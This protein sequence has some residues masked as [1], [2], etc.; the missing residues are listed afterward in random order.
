M[1]VENQ[2]NRGLQIRADF[3][4]LLVVAIWGSSY[5]FM[6]MGLESI[7]EF[8]LVALRF[9]FAFIL[10]GLFFYKRMM[11]V[12]KTT[13]KYGFILGTIV[14][15][16]ISCVTIGLQFTTVSNAGFS[17]GL[18]VIFVPL[19]LTIIYRRKPEFKI[20][21]ATIFSITGI[22]LMTLNEQLTINLGDL[23]CIIGALLYALYIITIDKLTKNVDSI[24]LGVLQLGFTGGWGL[25]FSFIF[26]SPHLPNS[27][28]GWIAILA[29]SIL[30]SAIG[31]IGQTVAQKY[32]TPTHTSLIFSLEPV[33]AA[34]FAF[35]FMNEVLQFRGYFGAFLIL[36]GVLTA[37]LDMKK[38]LKRKTVEA[39]APQASNSYTPEH[40]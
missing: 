15:L 17:F 9:G 29:L 24:A 36:L 14:F 2:M 5:L 31:F 35:M 12:D 7:S 34:L 20:I 40:K 13:V 38:L 22:G 23:L 4:M 30:C 25:V 21:V 39:L 6:K 8:N 37:E 3:M 10:A 32:T 16:A 11:R 1:K 33:F 18:A 26:E 19:L 27:S 28:E